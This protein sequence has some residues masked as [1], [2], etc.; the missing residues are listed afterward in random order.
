MGRKKGFKHSEETKMKIGD[1]NS[2]NFFAICD[3]CDIKY[4]TRPSHY[5]KKKKHF[6]STKCYSEYRKD[7]PFYEQHAYK[8]VRK[9]DQSKQI[10]YNNYCKKHPKRI[11]HL[12][13]RRYAREKGAEG[14]HTFQEWNDL[15]VEFNNKCAFCKKDEKITK[16]HIIPLSKGGSDYIDNI[17]PLC[18][19]CNSKKNNN[20]YEHPEIKYIGKK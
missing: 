14:K 5:K 19:S 17:Q 8:G 7:A 2:A 9:I 6:C 3:N 10:Y 1:A 20:I 15:L 11:A 4:K 16:D 12:K 18:K 13:A